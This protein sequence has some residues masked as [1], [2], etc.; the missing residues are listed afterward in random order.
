M[1]GDPQ[2][3]GV[4]TPATIHLLSR[5]PVHTRSVYARRVLAQGRGSPTVKRGPIA[6]ERTC[7]RAH[8]QAPERVRDGVCRVCQLERPPLLLMIQPHAS[9]AVRMSPSYLV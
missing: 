3:W 8:K 4:G 2:K 1:R 7:L 9:A 6:G 5:R